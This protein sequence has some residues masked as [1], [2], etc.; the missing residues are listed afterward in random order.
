MG[1]S[2]AAAI[3]TIAVDAVP[4]NTER[5][6]FEKSVNGPVIQNEA[7]LTTRFHK[8]LVAH[9]RKVMRYRIIPVGSAT[10]Y[11]DLADVTD[12][13]LYEAKGSA[14]RMSVRL[15]LGQVLDYGHYV[16][17]SRLAVLLPS[18]PPPT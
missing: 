4:V 7:Q 11:S 13:V 10:L 6:D 2:Q 17:G 15:A 12:N 1:A 9:H 8:Y 5:S 16:D 18:A 3:A 14:E